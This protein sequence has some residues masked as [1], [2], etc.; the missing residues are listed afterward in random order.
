MELWKIFNQLH[1]KVFLNLNLIGIFMMQH[2]CKAIIM[3]VILMALPQSMQFSKMCV[4]CGQITTITAFSEAHYD[5]ASFLNCIS[6][7]STDV[8]KVKCPQS[9]AYLLR[10]VWD[11]H[12]K[13]FSFIFSQHF[14]TWI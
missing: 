14:S 2:I 9:P 1:F 3:G 7:S 6:Q 10:R 13:C 4:C 11:A 5:D 8:T 12:K